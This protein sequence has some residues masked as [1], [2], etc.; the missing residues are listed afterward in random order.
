MAASCA[1]N[2]LW[3]LVSEGDRKAC[4]GMTAVT[5]AMEASGAT[6]L[7]SVWDGTKTPEALTKLAH[8]EM[9]KDG[10]VRFTIFE[11]S[12]VLRDFTD[13]N[14]GAH[15]MATWPVVYGIEGLKE[16]LF[17]HSK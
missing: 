10:N 5:D 14:P 8:T 7:R 13:P 2:N 15:H 9:E 4:P 6:V 17:S 12:T 11:G 1:L 3:I 16:W